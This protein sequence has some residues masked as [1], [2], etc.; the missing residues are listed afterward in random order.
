KI[1]QRRRGAARSG[2]GLKQKQAATQI[3]GLLTERVLKSA[4]PSGGKSNRNGKK[5]QPF[6]MK[7]ENGL[8]RD[9]SITQMIRLLA[10]RVLK[11]AH[12]LESSYAG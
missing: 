3:I 7:P 10:E 1:R 2:N 5:G 12:Y 9:N 4:H 8:K 6:S 11:S